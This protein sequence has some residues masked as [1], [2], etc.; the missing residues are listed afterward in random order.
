[1]LLCWCQFGVRPT[2][3]FFV[4][5]VIVVLFVIL[6]FITS[7]H[8]TL[9][10]QNSLHCYASFN[11]CL[12]HKFL[13][14]LLL[15]HKVLN[16]KSNNADADESCPPSDSDSKGANEVVEPRLGGPSALADS[17]VFRYCLEGTWE[18]SIILREALIT[19]SHDDIAD[20]AKRVGLY[21]GCSHHRYLNNG[22]HF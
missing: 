21:T 13:Y 15:N 8:R 11:I 3:F 12:T 19:A 14:L 17:M 2:P 1:M 20:F 7:N 18:R 10:L 16:A 22:L 5:V 6:L 9:L 4:L